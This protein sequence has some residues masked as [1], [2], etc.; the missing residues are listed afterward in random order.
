MFVGIVLEAC[1]VRSAFALLVLCFSF[2]SISSF[3]CLFLYRKREWASGAFKWVLSHQSY[4]CTFSWHWIIKREFIVCILAA[5][6]PMSRILTLLHRKLYSFVCV[7]FYLFFSHS[8][9]HGILNACIHIETE[10]NTHTHMTTNERILKKKIHNFFFI[11]FIYSISNTFSD[12]NATIALVAFVNEFF[13]FICAFL[14]SFYIY[15][16]FTRVY[17]CM[18]RG[19]NYIDRLSEGSR[20]IDQHT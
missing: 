14:H 12:F 17:L 19:L 4:V 13:Y 20:T 11:H 8:S 2:I 3:L 16:E 10:T 15:I 7:F 9:F 6:P 1:Y 18:I 5:S